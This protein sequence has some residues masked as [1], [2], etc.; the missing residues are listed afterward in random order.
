MQASSFSRERSTFVALGYM[1]M[2]CPVASVET[3]SLAEVAGSNAAFRTSLR[4]S[5][6]GSDRHRK[7]WRSRDHGGRPNVRAKSAQRYN[8]TDRSKKGTTKYPS[9]W[10]ARQKPCQAS[11]SLHQYPRLFM[12]A[13]CSTMLASPLRFLPLCLGV[14]LGPLNLDVTPMLG[15]H[16]TQGGPPVTYGAGLFVPACG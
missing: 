10:P 8:P 6:Y 3:K 13:S 2:T 14:T 1:V 11:P 7:P 4:L 5:R 9:L 12:L 16:G 15:P